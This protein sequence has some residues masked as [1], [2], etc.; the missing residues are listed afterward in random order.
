MKKICWSAEIGSNLLDA[1][2]VHC[3]GSHCEKSKRMHVPHSLQ[4]ARKEHVGMLHWTTPNVITGKG[5]CP[6]F[7]PNHKEH[8]AWG[9]S[10]IYEDVREAFTEMD[11]NGQAIKFDRYKETE[12]D[13]K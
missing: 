11:Y 7:M 2:F 12:R 3:P 6:L 8:Y 4:D 9:I 13:R 5:A 10:T 1:D